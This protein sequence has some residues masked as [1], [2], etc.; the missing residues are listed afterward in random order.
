MQ[1]EYPK[2]ILQEASKVVQCGKNAGL[3]NKE[4][5]QRAKNKA[6]SKPFKNRNTQ[7]HIQVLTKALQN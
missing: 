2:T 4:I 1:T 3:T 5:I 6:K 7:T